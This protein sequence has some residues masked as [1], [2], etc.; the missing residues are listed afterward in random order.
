MRT[1]AVE[2]WARWQ[3]SWASA[4]LVGAAPRLRIY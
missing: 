4:A 2:G 1:E 3:L